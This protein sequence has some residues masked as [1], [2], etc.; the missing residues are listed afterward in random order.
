MLRSLLSQK[1]IPGTNINVVDR[2]TYQRPREYPEHF[3][4]RWKQ[5]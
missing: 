1:M 3:I 2:T 5:M 4:N